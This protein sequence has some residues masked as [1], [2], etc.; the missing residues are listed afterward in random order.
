MIFFV[1][2]KTGEDLAGP[3]TPE[4]ALT[5]MRARLIDRRTLADVRISRK[6]G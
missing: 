3:F 5:W 6:D 4:E 2:K 1:D